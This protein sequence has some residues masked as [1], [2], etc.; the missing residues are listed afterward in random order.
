VWVRIYRGDELVLEQAS[1]AGLAQRER[2]T[3]PSED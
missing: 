1:P 2:W 3:G